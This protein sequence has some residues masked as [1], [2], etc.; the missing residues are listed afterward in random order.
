MFLV[1]RSFT[2]SVGYRR[3]DGYFLWFYSFGGNVGGAVFRG[4]FYL[5]GSFKRNFAG[6]YLGSATS[7]RTGWNLEFYWGGVTLRDGAHY[8]AAHYE[9]NRCNRVGGSDV[10]VSLCDDEGFDRLRRTRSAFLRADSS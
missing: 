9:I 1:R 4:G 10:E 6:D 5:L 8:S 7:D 2:A 3:L